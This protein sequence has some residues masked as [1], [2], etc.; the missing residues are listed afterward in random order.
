MSKPGVRTCLDIKLNP[1]AAA[2]AEYKVMTKQKDI[3]ALSAQVH[4]AGSAISVQTSLAN[5]VTI[6]YNHRG[7]PFNWIIV[8]DNQ[9]AALEDHI[10]RAFSEELGGRE[11][12]QFVTHMS[13]WLT[14]R[15]LSGWKIEFSEVTLK[16]HQLLF[17]FPGAYYWG[18]SSGYSIME[19]RYH[20]GDNWGGDNYRFCSVKSPLCTIAHTKMVPFYLKRK[21]PDDGGWHSHRVAIRAF[22]FLLTLSICRRK[23]GRSDIT[24][25]TNE[26]TETSCKDTI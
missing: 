25:F 18:F 24:N 26:E 2:D 5:F 1:V 12:S 8:P 3:L 19:K 9:K 10:R 17:V 15:L 11:C 13:L 22:D 6:F 21:I 23:P 14:L 16:E 7:Q 4:T 20:A